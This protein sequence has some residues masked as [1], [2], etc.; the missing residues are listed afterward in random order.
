MLDFILKLIIQERKLHIDN[1]HKVFRRFNCWQGNVEV[2]FVNDF[3]GVMTRI[4]YFSLMDSPEYEKKRY[5]K[6]SY[7]PF[8]EEYFE[9]IDLLEAILEAAKCFTMIELG[10]GWGRWLCRGVAALRQYNNDLL[11][12]LVGVEAEPTH[13]K[14]MIEHLTDN[15]V[16]LARCNIV[17]AAVSNKDGECRFFVGDAEASYGQRIASPREK[18]TNIRQVKGVCLQTLLRDLDIVDLIDSDI[19][20]AEL[21]V[22][23]A[24][25][26]SSWEKIKRVHI[27]THSAEA[28]KGLRKLFSKLGWQNQYDFPMGK[29]VKTEYGKISFQDGVQSWINPRYSISDKPVQ[30]PTKINWLARLIQKDKN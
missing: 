21:T 28:E 26:I 2:G 22:M 24:V 6:S 27:G 19:Q 14:W 8:D 3:L 9:W 7:P 10:A 18:Q 25:P 16:D 20:G 12:Q 29:M 4:G 17:E 5:I 13:Y 30:F 1:H 11:Y 23:S 15:K